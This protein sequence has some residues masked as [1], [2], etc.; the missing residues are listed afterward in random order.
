MMQTVLLISMMLLALAIT[1][2][3][4][5]VLKGPSI[6][7]RIAALDTIGVNVA[8]EVAVAGAYMRSTAYFELVLLI[9]ILAF[10]GTVALARYMERGRVLNAPDDSAGD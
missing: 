4:F 2:C 9:G 5:R 7:D 6:A 10:I 8:A 1:G 3:L